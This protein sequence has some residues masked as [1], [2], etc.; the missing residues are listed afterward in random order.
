[1]IDDDSKPRGYDSLREALLAIAIDA[2]NLLVDRFYVR[3]RSGAPG[4]EQARL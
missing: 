3:R 4:G 1:M 2:Q